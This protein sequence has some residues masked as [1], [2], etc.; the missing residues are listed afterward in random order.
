[1]QKLL[2]VW[3]NV[4]GYHTNDKIGSCDLNALRS[5]SKEDSCWSLVRGKA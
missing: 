3:H 5:S 2:D 1:M 4:S